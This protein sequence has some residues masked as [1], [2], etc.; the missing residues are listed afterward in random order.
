MMKI[1]VNE[2]IVTFS[3]NE[4]VDCKY[5]ISNHIIFENVL[6]LLLKVPV[7]EKNNTNILAFNEYGLL[8]WQ[9]ENLFKNNDCPYNMMKIDE[10]E[11]LHLYNWCGFVVKLNP[12]TGDVI[13]RIFTK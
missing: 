3:N 2:N 4:K 13:D 7:G 11:L 1:E 5:V 8:K 12:L 6:I 10:N 9:I